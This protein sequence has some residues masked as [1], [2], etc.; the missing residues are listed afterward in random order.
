[1][2]SGSP[3]ARTQSNIDAIKVLRQVQKENR[4]ATVDAS[5]AEVADALA[6]IWDSIDNRFGQLVYD[7]LFWHKYT[8]DLALLTVRLP[9]WN[10]GDIREIAGGTVDTMKYLGIGGKAAVRALLMFFCSAVLRT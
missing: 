4:A 6:K 7:N 2:I 5:A 1:V 8:K 10:V 9:G 3:E